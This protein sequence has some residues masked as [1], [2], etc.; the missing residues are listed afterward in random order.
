MYLG[1]A[2]TMYSEYEVLGAWFDIICIFIRSTGSP[3][4]SFQLPCSCTAGV[5]A[6]STPTA[7]SCSSSTAV[8]VLQRVDY[9]TTQSSGLQQQHWFWHTGI[10]TKHPEERNKREEECCTQRC[11]IYGVE[12]HQDLVRTGIILL[13][14]SINRETSSTW[15][16]ALSLN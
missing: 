10:H 4:S 12:S 9:V 3:I 5:G 8:V 16:E 14:Y 1:Y 7:V 11:K 2:V 6:A 13:L 15:R